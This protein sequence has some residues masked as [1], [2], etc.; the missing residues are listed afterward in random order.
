MA[1][2]KLLL[3]VALLANVH[4]CEMAAAVSQHLA[5]TVL[6]VVSSCKSNAHFLFYLWLAAESFCC[7]VS[8]GC[9]PCGLKEEYK[10]HLCKP[11]LGKGGCLC[12]SP[13]SRSR[14]GANFFFLFTLHFFPTYPYT[15]HHNIACSWA[16]SSESFNEYSKESLSFFFSGNSTSSYKLINIKHSP[17]SSFVQKHHAVLCRAVLLR[18]YA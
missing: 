15:I 16:W 8:F 18:S 10:T 4:S 7:S 3:S 9:E 11:L 17:S 2:T 5:A 1:E 13:H 14:G 12:T 6:I